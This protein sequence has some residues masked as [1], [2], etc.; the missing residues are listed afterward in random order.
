[1]RVLL[2]ASDVLKEELLN[3]DLSSE[4]SIVHINAIAT[5]D[6]EPSFDACIDL[7]FDNSS[8]RIEWLR[9]LG[10]PLIVVNSVTATSSQNF[11]DF[12]RINGWPGFIGKPLIEAASGGNI[13]DKKTEKLFKLFGKNTEWVPDQKGLVSARVISSI[14]NEAFYTLE[15]DVSTEEQID[16]AMKLGTNYPF[17]PFEWCRRIGIYNVFYLLTALYEDQE[18]YQ[19]SSLLKQKALA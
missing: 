12:V 1:M 9:N 17:G 13:P 8:D 18:R 3:T 2:I 15:E 5:F 14:I 19:P 6:Q 7:L 11:P 4:L 10:I 16:T